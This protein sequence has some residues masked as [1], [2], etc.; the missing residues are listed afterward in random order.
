MKFDPKTSEC[1][2]NYVYALIDPHGKPFYIGKGQNNRIFNHVDCKLDKETTNDKYGKIK[3]IKS[4]GADVGHVI[5]KHGMTDKVAYE[6]ESSLIDFIGYLDLP[7]TNEISGHHSIDSGLMTAD[8]VMRKYN[9]KPLRKLWDPVI[10]ININK[11]YGRG[12]GEEG[13]Y[14]ATKESWIVAKNKIEAKSIK[15]ALSEYRGLIVEVYEIEDWYPVDTKDK[16]GKP[17]TRWGF[18]GAVAKANVR[19]KYLNKSVAHIKKPGASN[20]IRYRL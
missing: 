17:K 12:C 13:I 14:S 7:L 3:E 11:T 15:Y 10:I 5:I 20:P 18:N 19:E 6:V 2:Q 9:A 4:S 8:E 1:L 16:N